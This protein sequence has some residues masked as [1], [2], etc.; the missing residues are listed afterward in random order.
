[1]NKIRTGDPVIVVTGKDK[2]RRGTVL[3]LLPFQRLLV[4]GINVAKKHIKGNPQDP[5]AESGIVDKET[6][7]HASNVAVYNAATKKGDKVGIRV[8]EDGTRVRYFK[9]TDELVDL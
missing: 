6:S 7:I 3:K 4:E 2:G 8:Q 1:M 9:S 5:A